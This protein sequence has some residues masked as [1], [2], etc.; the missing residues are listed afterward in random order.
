MSATGANAVGL[1]EKTTGGIDSLLEIK[2]ALP[3]DETPFILA[4]RAVWS[5]S[6]IVDDMHGWQMGVE[7]IDPLPGVPLPTPA[8][9]TEGA[10]DQLAPPEAGR[11][12]KG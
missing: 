12:F 6:M 5:A 11:E 10:E 1:G 3:A 2:G 4:A 8:A 7:F 9:F